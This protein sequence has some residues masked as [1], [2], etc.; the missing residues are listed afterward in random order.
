MTTVKAIPLTTR[1]IYRHKVHGRWRKP[2]LSSRRQKRILKILP[3]LVLGDELHKPPPLTL[4][5]KELLLALAEKEQ[6]KLQRKQENRLK[7]AQRPRKG[8]LKEQKRKEEKAKKIA[9]NLK[10]MPKLIAEM[11]EK[12]K[13]ERHKPRKGVDIFQPSEEVLRLRRERRH[14][15]SYDNVSLIKRVIVPPMMHNAYLLMTF[16]SQIPALNAQMLKES[17]LEGTPPFFGRLR[18]KRE[19]K[20]QKKLAKT[21]AP[22]GQEDAHKQQKQS[23]QQQKETESSTSAASKTSPATN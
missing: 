17:G 10:N 22:Q 3:E 21:T 12:R 5:Q 4:Q 13:A 2:I 16:G 9:E 14:R 20:A 1:L 23:R 7:Q 15:Q 8:L 18:L 11:K 6:A 19:L